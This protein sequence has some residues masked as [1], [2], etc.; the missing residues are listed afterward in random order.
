M[1]PDRSRLTSTLYKGEIVSLQ[2]AFSDARQDHAQALL[3]DT[4]L[5]IIHNIEPKTGQLLDEINL[6]EPEIHGV[7]VHNDKIW[8]CCAETGRYCTV[9]L[10]I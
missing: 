2:L 1:V 8:F 9:D 6:P 5:G 4:T 10:P 7:T 3:G